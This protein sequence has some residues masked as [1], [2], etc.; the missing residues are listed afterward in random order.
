[1]A[2]ITDIVKRFRSL[3][4]PG[5]PTGSGQVLTG[6]YSDTGAYVTPQTA[7]T[8]T[9]VNACVQA[10]ATEIAKLPW[11]V[12]LESRGGRIIA[13]DHPVHGLIR[14][15]AS[16]DTSALMWRELMVSSALLT[17]NGYS[18]IERDASG[19][20]IAL[21][22]LRPDLMNVIRFE[23]DKVAYV[24][25]GGEGRQVWDSYDIFHLMW[26]SPDGLLGY[27]PI[28]LA[29]QAIGLSLA[30]ETFGAAYYR[31]ASRPA[32]ALV[33][34]RELSIE[35]IQRIRESWEARMK[36]AN[37]AGSVAVLEG[38]LKWQSISLSP[39]DSQWL[40]SREFQR[41][42]ICSIFRVP[43]SVIGI[44][45]KQSYASAEQANRE[46]VSSCLSSW[47]ARLES[48][49]QRKLLR[50]DEPYV[51]E[52]SFDAMLRTDLM[53]RY[54][55]FSIARQFGF[56]SVNEIRAEI[57]RSDIGDA[58]D[59]YLQPTN[60]VPVSN[61]FGGAQAIPPSPQP[62]DAIDATPDEPLVD[63]DATDTE[64]RADADGYKPTA[65]MVTEA[66]RGLEW[67][68]EYKR[69]GTPVGVARARDI[70][71]GKRLPLATVKR[72]HSFFSRHE[73]DKKGK[74]FSP[75]EEGFPSAG[76]IAWALWGG[77]AGQSWSARIVATAASK[78]SK[79]K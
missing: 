21:R 12:L 66:E 42:E 61:A 24:Y 52:I 17:G 30:Q 46:W 69:G 18:L 4:S 22:F 51:T 9:T 71:N 25:S 23:A 78:K 73:V 38:G 79:T 40:Q 70:A 67:R 74:G 50:R 31:N 15:S 27:S 28:S 44:G 75:S 36:G 48:E 59:A 57:G 20:P 58:G 11:S 72:M 8:C 64:E 10:I 53:T 63:V 2:L 29:R 1:M 26:L 14:H 19:R 6:Q 49:A 43:P 16:E 47:A 34:D 7:L 32:G 41:E 13:K 45:Q 55:T 68:R 62:V 39:Q 3:V 60:M 56:L 35:A 54:Q 76:R 65:G 5:L 37:S 77:D 33:S